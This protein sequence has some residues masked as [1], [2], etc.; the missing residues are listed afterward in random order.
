MV[1][2]GMSIES[3]ENGGLFISGLKEAAK[4]FYGYSA[5]WLLRKSLLSLNDIRILGFDILQDSTVLFGFPR[6]VL[7]LFSVPKLH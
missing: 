4:V 7:L 5:A 3:T 6:L 1:C 2:D